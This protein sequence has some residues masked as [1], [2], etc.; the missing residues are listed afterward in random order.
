M[1]KLLAILLAMLLVLTGA[2]FA[3]EGELIVSGKAK[4]F[5]E[6]DCVSASVG[7]SLSGEDLAA[8]QSEANATVL[9]ICEA[10]KAAGLAEKDISTNYIY[11]SPRYDYS[12]DREE[13]IG[14]TINNSLTITTG[15]MD[16]IGEFIDAAFSA[17]ANTMDSISFTA[18]DSSAAS[19]K[20]LELAV[21]DARAKAETI[22]AA[23]GKTLGEVIEIREGGAEEYYYDNAVTGARY[24]MTEAA[25][26]AAGTT[27][28]ASQVSV[29]A[30]VQITYE[31]K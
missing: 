19:L 26:T 11:M 24:A 9:A 22:A 23:S 14:Y 4:V 25:D 5:M 12:S 16:R 30:E 21:Q 1:K 29:S 13:I 15:E 8:L 27:V 20:A 6:A 17:G 31:L 2:A 3:D 7:L 18:T 28:R 10:L